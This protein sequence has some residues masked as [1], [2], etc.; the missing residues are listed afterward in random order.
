MLSD[1]YVDSAAD[2]S[3]AMRPKRWA[4]LWLRKH[5]VNFNDC[6]EVRRASWRSSRPRDAIVG[7]RYVAAWSTPARRRSLARARLSIGPNAVHR[8]ARPIG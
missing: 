8:H 1:S 7:L 2:G 6:E 5:I 4:A 3:A